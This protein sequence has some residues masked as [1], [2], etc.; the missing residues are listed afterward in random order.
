MYQT[1]TT[2]TST[3]RE[4]RSSTSGGR[5]R[6]CLP[7][8][9]RGFPLRVVNRL[10]SSPV[11]QLQ[12]CV[13]LEGG[14]SVLARYSRLIS[15]SVARGWS[16]DA[17]CVG[18]ICMRRPNKNSLY[19]PQAKG[20]YKKEKK[21]SYTLDKRFIKYKNNFTHQSQLSAPSLR[22][23]RGAPRRRL[24][25]ARTPSRFRN[26]C[27]RSCFGRKKKTVASNPTQKPSGGGR[28]KM[29]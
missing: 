10:N 3:N 12:W 4:D 27:H 13:C 19:S 7:A 20:L 17:M 21:L 28:A 6:A 25:P 18:A 23:Q 11:P 26:S 2:G 24:A 1:H 15:D 29:K 16:T 22:R 8:L 14:V 9:W 5:F